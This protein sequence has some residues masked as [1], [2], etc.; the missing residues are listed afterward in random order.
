MTGAPAPTDWLPDLAGRN[1]VKYLALVEAIAD[2]VAAGTL[3]PGDRLPTH[4]DLAWRLKVNTSTITQ[5]YREAARRH[6][7]SGEVGRGTYVLA[8]STEAALF[9]LRDAPEAADDLIDL[10]TNVPA[11]LPGEDLAAALAA[12]V[13]ESG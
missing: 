1:R 2:A 5:A 10:S 3:K 11:A 12:L 6:L 7:V 13:A 4:R 9:A 8:D